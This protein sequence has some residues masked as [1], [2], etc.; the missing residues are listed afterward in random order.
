MQKV[1]IVL[2]DIYKKEQENGDA[3]RSRAFRFSVAVHKKDRELKEG[4]T[5]EALN[6]AENFVV[7]SVGKMR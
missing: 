4:N 6:W 1:K 7:S 5:A 2:N 3:G